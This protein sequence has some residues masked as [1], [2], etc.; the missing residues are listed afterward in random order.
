MRHLVAA[1]ALASLIATPA[2]AETQEQLLGQ[3]P[4]KTSQAIDRSTMGRNFQCQ[5]CHGRSG[6]PWALWTR[7]AW[8]LEDRLDDI[9]DQIF[10][11]ERDVMRQYRHLGSRRGLGYSTTLGYHG[12]GWPHHRRSDL[13]NLGHSGYRLRQ[14]SSMNLDLINFGNV[15]LINA[16]VHQR[17]RRVTRNHALLQHH[18]HI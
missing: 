18:R 7:R 15:D 12:R 11:A 4:P 17:N 2:L 5:F 13:Y 10:E 14:P 6:R 9:E 3:G 8:G 1:L 16:P